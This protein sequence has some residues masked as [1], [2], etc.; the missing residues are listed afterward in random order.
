MPDLIPHPDVAPIPYQV[1]GKLQSGT[2]NTGSRFSPGILDSGFG[3]ND[4]FWGKRLRYEQTITNEKPPLLEDGVDR[5]Q[6]SLFP[7]LR[8]CLLDQ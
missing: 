4:D 2:I 3:R 5:A 6:I 1:R 8:H 7:R